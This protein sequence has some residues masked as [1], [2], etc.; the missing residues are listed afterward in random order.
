MAAGFVKVS[1]QKRVE[2]FASKTEVTIFYDLISAA[3]PI[4]FAVFYSLEVSQ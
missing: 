1:R 3:F 2:E 4:P